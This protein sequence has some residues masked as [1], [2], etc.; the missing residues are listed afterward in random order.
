M[1]P[2][3]KLYNTSEILKAELKRATDR[4]YWLGVAVGAALA[5]LL[6]V[7][8]GYGLGTKEVVVIVS[9]QHAIQV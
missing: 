4:S 7:A 3:T 9:E 5:L 6:G 8:I 1:R 2:S